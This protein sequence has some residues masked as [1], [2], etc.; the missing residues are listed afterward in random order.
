A[1][2]RRSKR[3]VVIALAAAAVVVMFGGFASWRFFKSS[4]KN[5]GDLVAT[6]PLK[7]ERL[8]ASG[9][10]RNAAISPDGK[11]V[12]YTQM[13]KGRYSIWIRELTTNTNSE[14]VSPTDNILGI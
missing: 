8:T 7:I 9:Q 1:D 10:S 4:S 5:L 3:R 11:Y 12:A 14:I 2:R 6:L 13:F